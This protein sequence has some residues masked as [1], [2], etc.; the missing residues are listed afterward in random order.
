MEN[1][2]RQQ[3]Q[4]YLALLL[5][6][7]K[8][9]VACLLAALTVGLGGYLVTPKTYR[10]V[11]LLS[12]ERQRITPARMAPEQNNQEVLETISTL[13]DIV[14]SRRNLEA[15]I[16]K[17][18]LYPEL[19]KQVPSEEVAK[20]VRKHITI[21]PAHRGDNFTVVFEGGDPE[22]VQQVTNDIAQR[23]IDENLKYREERAT[24]TSRY[25]EDELNLAKAVLDKKEQAMRDYKLKYYNSLPEQRQNNLTRLNALHDQL[26]RVQD[27]IQ[28]L[29]R[30]KVMVQGQINLRRRLNGAQSN[31]AVSPAPTE[32]QPLTGWQRLQQLRSH[33]ISLQGRYTDKHPE[34][35][36]TRQ[37]IARL[38]GEASSQ[39]GSVCYHHAFKTA[40]PCGTK[41]VEQMTKDDNQLI[42]TY[43]SFGFF[44]QF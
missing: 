25:T 20:L 9:L 33:L 21:A 35:R 11:A 28:N 24:E 38:E 44:N 14:I 26:Q 12:Y 29:E 42:Q 30:T 37:L 22:Q 2:Q 39:S 3:V 18:D 43:K 23:F 19:R 34:V 15:I 7:W 17:F 31:V 6:H 4:K 36:R 13:R 40:F 32:N 16:K 5:A 10:C 8:L 1:Q 27:S 41:S